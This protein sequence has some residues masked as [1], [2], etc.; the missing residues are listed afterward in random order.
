M[1]TDL[2]QLG[3]RSN[4]T[5]CLLQT[6]FLFTEFS[7]NVEFTRQQIHFFILKNTLKITLK[8]T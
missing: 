7:E 6:L 5:A 3:I 8:Y 1:V 4:G 2:V